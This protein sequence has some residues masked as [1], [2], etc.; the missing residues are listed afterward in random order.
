M[1]DKFKKALILLLFCNFL[2]GLEGDFTADLCPLEDELKIC[3]NDI[4]DESKYFYMFLKNVF[5]C[6]ILIYFSL[7][8]LDCNVP[9]ESRDLGRI[10]LCLSNTKPQLT[11]CVL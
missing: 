5:V 10:P 11:A 8:G 3:L 7:S 1:N 6:F 4:V 2:V 9:L